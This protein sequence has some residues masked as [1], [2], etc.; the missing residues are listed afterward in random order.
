[1]VWGKCDPEQDAERVEVAA[2]D[3]LEHV[4]ESTAEAGD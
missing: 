2:L 4:E 3:A 1:V